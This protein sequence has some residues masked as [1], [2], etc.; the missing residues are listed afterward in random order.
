MW[1][2][3]YGA[4]PTFIPRYTEGQIG[5]MDAHNSYLLIAAE[6]GIPT[7]LVFLLILVMAWAYSFWLYHHTTDL[8]IKAIA[9][10]VMAGLVG[11]VVANMFGSRMDDQAVSSYFWI[12]CGLI[13]RGVLIERRERLD[14]RRAARSRGAT[15]LV[16]LPSARMRWSR[17]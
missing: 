6:M 12:L 1:G 4:F 3:G 16:P 7:L 10:G 17:R 13:M 5:E 8:S 11:L 15:V 9:L 2:I 14:R